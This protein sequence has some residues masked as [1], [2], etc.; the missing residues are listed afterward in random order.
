M[1]R[2]KSPDLILSENKFFWPFVLEL[3]RGNGASCARASPI[4]LFSLKM[5]SGILSEERG[6]IRPSHAGF[7]RKKVMNFSLEVEL[8]IHL[9]MY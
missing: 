4:N 3:A 6:E 1:P 5:K 8:V 9:T 2:A 7:E